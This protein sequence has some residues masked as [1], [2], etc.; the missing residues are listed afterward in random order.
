MATSSTSDNE[1]L[2]TGQVESDAA[3]LLGLDTEA[4]VPDFNELFSEGGQGESPDGDLAIREFRRPTKT[5]L[6]TPQP[7]FKDKAFYKKVL[8][9]EGDVSK[10]LHGMLASFL[11]AEDPQDR[12]MHRSRLI[13]AYWNLLGSIAPKIGPDLPLAKRLAIRFGIDRK[14]VV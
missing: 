3:S 4:D 14:S 10:R 5:Q 13:P 1:N 8:T 6:D 11:N 9:G 12:S 7:Y 2:F